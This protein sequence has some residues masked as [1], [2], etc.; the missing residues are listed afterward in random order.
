MYRKN[1]LTFYLCVI[2]AMLALMFVVVLGLQALYFEN[3][4]ASKSLNATK[5]EKI[6]PVHVIVIS[7]DPAPFNYV[8][9]GTVRSVNNSLV[10]AETSGRVNFV[11]PVGTQVNSGD[12]I[13]LLD[14]TDAL[15]EVKLIRL[16]LTK[17]QTIF[18]HAEKTYNRYSKLIGDEREPE[19]VLDNFRAKRD[20]AYSDIEITKN[21][22]FSAEKKCRK[23]K[24]SA[25]FS[26]IVV[27]RKVQLAEFASLGSPIV[28]L[29]DTN[30]LEAVIKISQRQASGLSVGMPISI[31]YKNKVYIS[32]VRSIVPVS[33]EVNRTIEVRL[34]LQN[35]DIYPGTAITVEI[36]RM[37]TENRIVIHKDGLA[38]RS[39]SPVVFLVSELNLVKIAAVKIV[40]RD[41]VLVEVAG[42]LVAGDQIIVRGA[43]N[44]KS[45]QKV[46]VQ[47]IRTF[48]NM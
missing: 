48:D 30:N 38:T 41:G 15:Q 19:V 26:G 44:L 36:P 42:D 10:A 34:L 25:P 33:N 16:E 1:N 40:D 28:R 11:A 22:L 39:G 27:E 45:N 46:F 29:V 20:Q 37:E 5:A 31:K 12:T 14:D 47:K 23:A 13:A 3:T 21:K 6:A 2:L 4:P 18:D 17:L 8:A 35:A 9:H 7:D 32:E 43:E 24:I